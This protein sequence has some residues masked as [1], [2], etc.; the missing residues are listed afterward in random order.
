MDIQNTSFVAVVVPLSGALLESGFCQIRLQIAQA[1]T[2]EVM[3]GLQAKAARAV[4]PTAG[5]EK[6]CGFS[7]YMMQLQLTRG[8]L[9]RKVFHNDLSSLQLGATCG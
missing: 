3:T 1:I 5:S 2:K 6:C 8:V 7:A 4:A 9:A